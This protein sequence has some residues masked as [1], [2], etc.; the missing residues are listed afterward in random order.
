MRDAGNCRT[1]R[2]FIWKSYIYNCGRRRR[3]SKVVKMFRIQSKMNSAKGYPLPWSGKGFRFL[4]LVAVAHLL[5]NCGGGNDNDGDGE[6]TF[7]ALGAEFNRNNLNDETS[8]LMRL[9]AD[10][11]VRWQAF[12]PEALDEAKRVNRP[13]FLVVSTREGMAENRADLLFEDE[14]FAT[15][16]NESF[17]PVMV[18]ADERPDLGAYYL[19]FSVLLQRV[20]SWPLM[21]VT[22]PDGVPIE[23]VPREINGRIS[24]SQIM[25]WMRGF[26]NRWRLNSELLED[27]ADRLLTVLRDLLGKVAELKETESAPTKADMLSSVYSGLS[28]VADDEFGT[29]TKGRNFIRPTILSSLASLT[30]YF[31][32]GDFRKNRIE[33]LA[34]K[35]LDVMRISA[36]YD[37][38]FGGWYRDSDAPTWNSPRGGK[39]LDRKSVV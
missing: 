11:R 20:T 6:T 13:L 12:S 27:K 23:V 14:E 15:L 16:L 3:L 38:V 36:I 31:D 8:S 18:D 30:A 10:S 29:V 39:Y 7:L 28:T 22:T 21:L 9:M 35:S 5:M 25:S 37:H 24:Y 2:F 1:E 26:S 33:R 32:Q 19:E 4:G 34:K 17:V